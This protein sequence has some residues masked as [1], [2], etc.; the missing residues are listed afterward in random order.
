M[1]VVA[2]PNI[3]SDVTPVIATEVRPQLQPW[4]HWCLQL[5]LLGGMLGWLIL[6]PEC[7]GGF[8]NFFARVSEEL[9]SVPR[10]VG[11]L[12]LATGSTVG[13]SI[14]G[15]SFLVG[16]RRYRSVRSLLA[17]ATLVGCWIAVERGHADVAWQGKRLRLAWQLDPFD[18]IVQ[19]LQSN[20]PRDDGQHPLIGPYMA[21][22][23]GR[24]TTLVPLAPPA[25]SA[26]GICIS[27][28][29]RGSRGSLRF[30][31]SGTEQGGPSMRDW[32]EWH[33]RGQ[34]DSFLGGLQDPHTIDRYLALRDGWFL[35]RYRTR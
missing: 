11:F 6:D 10:A 29:E 32:L 33:P 34:P 17:L 13:M 25:V 15:I 23:F 8:R 5:V 20:W 12:A 22:P 2:K 30:Q 14:L 21:Y 7:P 9:I 3:R 28:I 4:H 16:A 27:I 24:P 26:D 31:L 19:S 35:V 18:S 1:S